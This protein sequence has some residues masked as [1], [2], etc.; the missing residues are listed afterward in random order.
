MLTVLSV[1]AQAMNET[2]YRKH[3]L[4]SVVC[5]C[6]CDVPSPSFSKM[7]DPA[8]EFDE[9]KCYWVMNCVPIFF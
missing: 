1:C 5:A 2:L 4:V 8:V 7:Q 9:C 6:V 3:W